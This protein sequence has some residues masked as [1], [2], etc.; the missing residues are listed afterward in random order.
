MKEG[1]STATPA[2][3]AS[4]AGLFKGRY[5]VMTACLSLLFGLIYYLHP[6]IQDDLWF[7]LPLNHDWSD[8]AG[9][10]RS[11][12]DTYFD[13]YSGDNG[14]LS[15]A[16]GMIILLL[17]R[18]VGAL[19]FTLNIYVDVALGAVIVGIWGR[20]WLLFALWAF[21]FTF[22]LPWFDYMFCV[23]YAVNYLTT[24]AFFL[25][26]LYVF[27]HK[28]R[29]VGAP[30]AFV[31]GLML[32]AWHEQFSCTALGSMVIV[33]LLWR[34]Y[35][36]RMNIAMVTGIILGLA[37]LLM[38]PGPYERAGSMELFKGFRLITESHYYGLPFYVY[39]AVCI[40]VVFTHRRHDIVSPLN[41]Y[42][43]LSAIASWVIWRFFFNGP[44]LVW[45][46]NFC[47]M[48]GLLYLAVLWLRQVAGRWAKVI[49]LAVW[50][51]VFAHLISVIPWT[52]RFGSEVNAAKILL[53]ATADSVT[54]F[55]YI[56][57]PD[58]APAYLL[59]KPNFNGTCY[60]FP[61]FDRV[62]DPALRH[63]R[64]ENRY[65]MNDRQNLFFY[66]GNIVSTDTDLIGIFSK[67]IVLVYDTGEYEMR[68]RPVGFVA[69]DGREY[70]VMKVANWPFRYRHDRLVN[71]Y[72]V[73][74]IDK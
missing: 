49:S 31:L 45:L 43:M 48:L 18:W 12:A 17:P 23:M 24:T 8:P 46:L 70:V 61:L 7:G 60:W 38:A 44:R 35:L 28:P 54:V 16:F 36:T 14:R 3:P 47:S 21:G 26:V 59:G 62:A 39:L 29:R 67:N 71:I 65:L 2:A 50:S 13:H 55:S 25:A 40:V 69:D 52:A 64:P 30:G 63:F 68:T 42:L 20:R 33:T 37:F 56:T 66:H 6:Y 32:G 53:D 57:P 19:F 27:I 41:T 73:Q 9:V 34:R 4:F 5:A 15:N 58:R 1:F 10:L 74:D 72:W 11:Y 22:A 51:V